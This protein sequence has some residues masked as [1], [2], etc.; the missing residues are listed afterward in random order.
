MTLHR[1][2]AAL[3]IVTLLI[4]T[5][6]AAQ[7]PNQVAGTWRVTAATVEMD[8][9]TSYPYGPEP[10]GKLVFTEDLH[11]VELLHDPRIPRFKS[12]QRGG[13]TDAENRAAMASSLALYGRYTVDADGHFSGNT[14]EGS[15]FPNWIGDVRTTRELRMEVHGNRMIERFQ[16]P[17]G[18]KVMIVWERETAAK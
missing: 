1:A 17:G 10:Q 8:G 5:T 6:V 16:R 9:A 14:V 12:N 15:S 13:G 3:A 7:T 4:A 18:A 2:K 11:F